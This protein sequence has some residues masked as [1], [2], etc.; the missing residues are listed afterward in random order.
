MK[1]LRE[2][3]LAKGMSQAQLGARLHV[4]QNTISNWENSTRTP[5]HETLREI[6]DYFN[7]SIDFLLGR[8]DTER[9]LADEREADKD[10]YE[11]REQLRR[12]PGMRILFKTTKNA[13]EDDIRKAVKIIEA[14][15]E[16]S[17]G[18]G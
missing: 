11:L 7:V 14:L 6:A 17:D 1:R 15:K 12:N 9:Y 2:L 4:T 10:L 18:N 3:R 8:D 5:D 13:S 16:E